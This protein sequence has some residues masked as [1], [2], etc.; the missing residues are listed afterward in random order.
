[1]FSRVSHPLLSR[2]KISSGSNSITEYASG[3]LSSWEAAFNFGW[4]GTKR[5]G[6]STR[7]LIEQNWETPDPQVVI[8]DRDQKIDVALFLPFGCNKKRQIASSPG[9]KRRSKI[10][11]FHG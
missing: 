7:F 6:P 2:P 1:M 11:R 4:R 9:T 8:G 5:T 10:A 3:V